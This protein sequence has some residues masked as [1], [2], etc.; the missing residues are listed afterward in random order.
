MA[1][2][3]SQLKATAAELAAR[4]VG[5][6]L[7]VWNETAKRWHGGDGVTVGGIAMARYDERNDGALGYMQRVETDAANAVTIADLGKVIIG[8]RATAIAFNL[9]PAADLTVGFVAAFKNINA[10]VMT[11]VPNGAELIDGVN[12]AVSLPTGASVV[13]KCDGASFRT[14]FSN[15]D[16]L[17][18]VDKATT[19][20]AAG[21]ATGGGDL[22]ANRTITVPKSSEAQAQAR[23]DDTVALT[24]FTGDKLGAARDARFM[25]V[26][27]QRA[28]GVSSTNST[29]TWSVREL[30]TV[31]HNGIAGASLSSNAV[32]LPAGTYRVSARGPIRRTGYA[33]L[34][35]WNATDGSLIIEGPTEYTINSSDY[36]YHIVLVEGVVTLADTKAIEVQQIS[37]VVATGGHG[38]A[39]ALGAAEI[40]T[41]IFI[42]RID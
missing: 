13:I 24:P 16:I 20:S 32:T 28:L 15:G 17:G 9:D 5:A 22:S 19:I 3:I 6:G 31:V 39:G 8:N 12:A 21:L 23:T 30:N 42:E 27:D 36:A 38:A 4:I 10:G 34:R 2:P 25:H 29:T 14:L 1:T 7:L 11:I 33:K 37:A 40:F 26:R 18:K 35:L 41:E